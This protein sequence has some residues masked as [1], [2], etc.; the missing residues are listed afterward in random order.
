M[1]VWAVLLGECINI[2]LQL[3]IESVIIK[4]NKSRS[5]GSWKSV[6]WGRIDNK[7]T[8]GESEEDC[9]M[10]SLFS[11]NGLCFEPIPLIFHLWKSSFIAFS[12]PCEAGLLQTILPYEESNESVSI[13]QGLDEAELLVG[14]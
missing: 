2:S 7:N 13:L 11:I 4:E 9:E 3:K 1:K 8:R 12:A 10:G 5:Q 6:S 14:I